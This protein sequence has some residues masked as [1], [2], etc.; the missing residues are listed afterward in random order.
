MSFSA[1]AVNKPAVRPHS[2]HW[3]GNSSYMYEVSEPHGLKTYYLKTDAVLRDDFPSNKEVRIQENH[4]LPYTRTGSSL[5]D[6]LFALALQEMIQSSVSVISDHSFKPA[7]CECFETGEKWKYVWT[8]D[9]SYAT[10][11]GLGGMDPKRAMNSLEFKISNFRYGL[12]E[13][14]QIVQDTGT[15]G[16]WP[17]STDRIIWALGAYKTL[18]HLP[19]KSEDFNRFLRRAYV[20]LKN[21]VLTDRQ[22]AYD[23]ADGLYTGEQSFLDW[24]EQSYPEWTR[25]NVVHIG[26]SKSLSTNVAQYIA[27]Q[28]L[29]E[30]T[31]YLNDYE[32]YQTFNQW[33]ENLK[34]AIIENFW[35]GTSLRS[36]KTSFLDQRVIKYYD[37]LGISLAILEDIP[38]PSQAKSALTN[39]PQ[40]LVGPP[41]IWPQLQDIPI[42]HNRAIWPFVTAYALKA[43]KKIKEPSLITAFTR[44]LMLGPAQNLSNME[45]FEFLTL[46]NWFNDGVLSG[47]V[48]NSRRQLWST[49]G[50]LSMVIDVVFGKEVQPDAIR[51]NPAIPL[52]LRK[53]IFPDSSQLTLN[54]L[55]FQNRKIDL[56]INLPPN[57]SQEYQ[58]RDGLYVI[59]KIVLN[60][61]VIPNKYW[62]QSKDLH[63]KDANKVQIYLTTPTS[64]TKEISVTKVPHNLFRLT[65]A[66]KEVY[67]Q[68]KTPNLAPIGVSDNY[69]LLS[70]HSHNHEDITYIV[71]KNGKHLTETKNTHYLDV[72]HPMS[73]TA[74]YTVVARYD[75][76]K[77]ESFPTEPFCYW[78]QG[79]IQHYPMGGHHIRAEGHVQHSS[80]YGRVF[81][82]DWGNPD[83]K[84]YLEHFKPNK[85]GRFAIQVDYNN[86]ERVNT[87]VTCG[88]KKVSVIDESTGKVISEGVLMFPHHDHDRYWTDSNF[89]AFH[90]EANK[91]YTFV[92]EDFQNM[93]YF[94]HF[95]SYKNRGGQVGYYNKF[96]LAEIK[97]LYLGN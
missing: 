8:R 37:L 4:H 29:S 74:C 75:S 61:Q 6:G 13:G 40:T 92:I 24:R 34:N 2:A 19:Y 41:V 69:P 39:Y 93:S 15:G 97:V 23:P 57:L 3:L 5:F 64:F 88:V 18:L 90:M 59:E 10:D 78:P 72:G 96:N 49:A 7:H 83:Q 20:A 52:Q 80:A 14:E 77:N 1:T 79:A 50:Y 51:F 81:L 35:D 32:N 91:S 27:L 12:G 22:A 82:K 44:S 38:E 67:F 84:V 66:E 62:I 30:L 25:T 26:M 17:V 43:A 28:R 46:R 89:V 33:A 58:G 73:E 60:G 70:F 86:L 85:S 31:L 11:L 16:S 45:N 36:L 56:E 63:T 21:S 65:R 68:P 47:P 53:E 76:S 87:G 9:I 54:N 42:Y 55:W 48:V 95:E 71:F 94:R